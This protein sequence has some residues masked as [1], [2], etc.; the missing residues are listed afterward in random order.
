MPSEFDIL[1]PKNER[2]NF[3]GGKNNKFEKHLILDN[4]SPDTL[5]CIFGDGSAET[6][7]GTL[8]FNSTAVGSFAGHGLYTRHDRTGSQTMCA[9]FNGSLYVSGANTFVTIPSAQS[10]FTAGVRVGAS[11]YENYIFFGNGSGEA[12]KYGSGGHF[13]RHGVPAPTVTMTVASGGTGVLSGP[14][15][16][17][18]TNVNSNLVESD[19]GPVTVTFVA[20]ANQVAITS[21]PTAPASHGVNARRLYR[22]TNSSTT[23]FRVVEIADNVTSSYVDNISDA[24]LG[25][26]APSDQGGPPKYS[27]I[28]THQNRLFCDDTENPSLIWYSE[29][30]N[31]Y[32]FKADNFEEI[33]DGSGDLVKGA[34]IHDNGLLV[35]TDRSQFLIYMP[36][37][38]PNDWEMVKL[39]SSYGS[40]SPF[41]SF[42]YNNKVMFPAV[43]GDKLVGF[44]AVSG[45]TVAPEAT[46]LTVSAS[47]SDMKSD[48][49]EPDVFDLQAANI[50]RISSSVFQNKAYIA[51]TYGDGNTTNNRIFV[52]DFS[53]LN[54][55]K[56][57]E[58]SWSPWT[59]LNAEQF[60]IFNS[61]LYYISSTA[62]GLVYEMNKAGRYDDDGTAI[63]SYF[64]TKEYS[65]NPGDEQYHKDFRYFNLLYE[66]AGG[67]Y[68]SLFYRV[69]SDIGDGNRI[70]INLNPGGSLWGSMVWGVSDWGGGAAE[71]ENRLYFGQ[72]RGKRV[73]F[74]F[75]NQNTVGQKFKVIGLQY[76]YNKKGRR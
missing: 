18:L 39:R 73:Q 34:A 42:T 15:R 47:G 63:N 76:S 71:G 36:T 60:T 62:N 68:M 25:A 54:L 19:V 69:D 56:K 35:N 9:W 2:Q 65:G 51:V 40:R 38:D 72:L 53:I 22:T 3:G 64:Y 16:W 49:I 10:I 67:Y 5:N 4:E 75:T 45:D 37:V 6:R 27:W 58:F 7:L 55:S 21:I 32:V 44:A 57:Q 11:E 30:G 59:G 17:L 74:K 31:P 29:L 1:Y 13:T 24:N 43:Q 28:I 61:K 70:N 33:G 14:Y 23:Y 66:K 41:G 50:G 20:S 8:R 48:R 26:E 46:L 12:Y 52:F